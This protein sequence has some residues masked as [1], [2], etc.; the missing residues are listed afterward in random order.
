MALTLSIDRGLDDP[1]YEQVADQVRRLVASGALGPGAALPSVRQL[2]GDLGVDLTTVT[3][4]GVDGQITRDDVRAAARDIGGPGEAPSPVDQQPE[5]MVPTATCCL[6]GANAFRGARRMT[7][8]TCY[9]P[10]PSTAFFRL[11]GLPPKLLAYWRTQG[12]LCSKSA[13]RTPFSRSALG[14]I[15]HTALLSDSSAREW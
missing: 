13:S 1:V 8:S 9:S 10:S 6:Q 3:G 4:T 12:D 2:A 15:S 11:P 7:R 5:P 14:R